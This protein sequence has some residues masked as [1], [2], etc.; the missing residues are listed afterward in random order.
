MITVPKPNKVG[1]VL[2]RSLTNS[3]VDKEAIKKN[4]ATVIVEEST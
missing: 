3:L 4:I 2:E 1:N